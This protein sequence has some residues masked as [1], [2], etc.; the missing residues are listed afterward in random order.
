MNTPPP[1]W[2]GLGLGTVGQGLLIA[3]ACLFLVALLLNLTRRP[4]RWAW[5]AFR[6]GVLTVGMAFLAHVAI[7]MLH[8]FEYDYV[9]HNTENQMPW[10]YRLSAAW[11]GQEGS[12]LLWCLTSAVAS[13]LVLRRIGAD[14]RIAGAISALFLALLTGVVSYETPFK[15]LPISPDLTALMPK[16]QVGILP[17]DGLGLNPALQNVWM[18]I[19]PIVIFS[20]FGILLPLFSWSIAAAFRADRADWAQGIRPVAIVGSTLM[21]VGLSMGGFWAYETLGWGGFWA[22][23]PVENVSL[24]PFLT[25]AVLVHVAYIGS[26][27]KQWLRLAPVIGALPFAWFAYGTFLARSGALAN[28][29]V[30]SFARMEGVAHMLLAGIVVMA[31]VGV[32]L[33]WI[34]AAKQPKAAAT[35]E[36]SRT[37][38]MRYALILVYACAIVAA[39]GMSFPYVVQSLRL[40]IGGTRNE[41]VI[42]ED[43]YNQLLVWPFIPMMFLVGLAPFMGWTVTKAARVRVIVT[44][45]IAAA[46]SAGALMIGL[47]SLGTARQGSI[48]AGLLASLFACSFCILANLYRLF[49][50]VRVR[51]GRYGPYVAHVGIGFMLCGLIVSKAFEQ[52]AM[53]GFS[54]HQA[55]QYKL[56]NTVY[57]VQLA[58]RP[59][60]AS[61]MQPE[62]ALAVNVTHGGDTTSFHPVFFYHQAIESDDPLQTITRPAIRKGLLADLY[63]SIGSRETTVADGIHL[64]PGETKTITV[65]TQTQPIQMG[66]RCVDASEASG[67]MGSSGAGLQLRANL[68]LLIGNKTFRISPTRFKGKYGDVAVGDACVIRLESVD[69]ENPMG[70]TLTVLYPE[71]IYGAELFMKPL[72]SFVWLGAG[73]LALGGLLAARGKAA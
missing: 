49:E 59:T 33:A 28:V 45:I 24:V 56:G 19:H 9:W 26:T 34:V 55:G 25:T 73:L 5:G 50:R 29:S 13:M 4:E 14:R 53:G 37:T 35:E 57:R 27:R 6:L 44:L 71:P 61:L 2:W 40:G 30:H 60:A 48:V 1:P 64:R 32:I 43:L 51:A 67:V 72:T 46:L 11:A 36:G 62:N 42:P 68:D 12:F 18:V 8:Q 23:D 63:L 54:T 16:G 66:I 7:L 38:T 39:L 20:G 52:T 17:P 3:S 70:A 31:V 58:S 15:L 47:E 41:R 10:I 65:S 22:W 21:G 69:H